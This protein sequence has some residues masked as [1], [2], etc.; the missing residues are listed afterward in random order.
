MSARRRWVVVGFGAVAFA[1]VY[2]FEINKRKEGS[3][4]L[5]EAVISIEESEV[6]PATITP[7]VTPARSGATNESHDSVH[8]VATSQATDSPQVIYSHGSFA[9]QQ[10]FVIVGDP[11]S[12]EIVQQI[13]DRNSLLG[14]RFAADYAQFLEQP[15]DWWSAD[16][17]FRMMDALR[18]IPNAEYLQANVL[19][20]TTECEVLLRSL[21]VNGLSS[22]AWEQAWDR[23]QAQEWFSKELRTVGHLPGDR[24]GQ[25]RMIRLL[26][27]DA[28]P[29]PAGGRDTP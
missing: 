13:K 20:R 14:E 1:L 29:V 17:E 10:P 7:S 22:R 11:L 12:M 15:A 18:D 4:E 28:A 21:P 2:T 24:G 5:S 9:S 27:R 3:R 8:A 25:F 16:M 19:C 6:Q 23:L 26:R